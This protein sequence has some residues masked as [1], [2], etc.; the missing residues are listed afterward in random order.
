MDY[1]RTH[2]SY[3]SFSPQTSFSSRSD[4]WQDVLA[5]S[6][7]GTVLAYFS[8]RQHFPGL[9]SK[10]SDRPYSPRVKHENTEML[11]T[12]NLHSFADSHGGGIRVSYDDHDDALTETVPR[13]EPGQLEDAWG[14]R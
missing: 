5:G 10:F 8:Y 3:L 11:P 13:P 7:L 12:H 2:L 9:A 4:H 14:E 1:R 6:I